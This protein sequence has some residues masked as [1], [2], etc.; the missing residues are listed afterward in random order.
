MN[1]Q[2]GGCVS[3]ARSFERERRLHANIDLPHFVEV[4]LG[5]PPQRVVAVLKPFSHRLVVISDKSELL[6]PSIG[7]TSRLLARGRRQ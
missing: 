7:V 3:L 1:N 2:F 6:D 5:K 4:Q